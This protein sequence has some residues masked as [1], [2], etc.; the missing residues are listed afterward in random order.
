VTV[1]PSPFDLPEP[2]DPGDSGSFR[3]VIPDYTM[4]ESDIERADIPYGGRTPG[5]YIVSGPVGDRR[6]KDTRHR[7]KDI[8]TA[9][10]VLKVKYGQRFVRMLSEGETYGLWAAEIRIP[11]SKE[12]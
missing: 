11:T 6:P 1:L 3:K 7:M 2:D 8:K 10:T 5:T 9:E 12:L 4:E